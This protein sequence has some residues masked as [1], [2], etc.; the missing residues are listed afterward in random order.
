MHESNPLESIASEQVMEKCRRRG[1][2]ISYWSVPHRIISKLNVQ[3]DNFEGKMGAQEP[4]E[5]S[6]VKGS[7]VPY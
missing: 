1:R 4:N 5:C 6:K 3:I 7:C 2:D